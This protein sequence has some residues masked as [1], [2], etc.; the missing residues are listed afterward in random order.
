MANRGGKRWI[1]LLLDILSVIAALSL[2]LS[3]FS[4]YTHPDTF[5]IIPVFGLAYPV[6]V[7]VF[8]LVM[9]VQVFFKR[10]FAL[11][12]FVLFLSG[13]GL[14]LRT[15][16]FGSGDEP[17]KNSKSLKIMSYNVRLFDFYNDDPK[18][19]Q[20]SRHKILEFLKDE[21]PDIVCFQEFYQQDKPTN[22][23]TKDTIIP[24][25][26]IKDY[27]ERYT[28][29]ER[30]R[31]N[32]GIALFS[33]YP[34]IEKGE[35]RFDSD[36]NS[37][38]YSIYSDIV[39]HK[40]T[41]RVY[42]IHL[43]SISLDSEE[44]AALINEKSKTGFFSAMGKVIEA[45]PERAKQ[46]E[47]IMNHIRNSPYPVVVCGDFNDTPLSYT[48]QRF[49]NHLTDAY[50]N[51]RTGIG[52]TYAGEI[53]AGRIDYIFHSEALGSHQF[54]IQENAL[55]DHYAISCKVFVK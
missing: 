47:R 31:R 2:L 42:N 17:P 28:H 15:F 3:Y 16:T 5:S 49:H 22:F 34:I 50:R 30:G 9:I 18:Q 53:P 44:R 25:L 32:Y 46:A 11:G 48:Y 54:K 1:R 19:A 55:S 37:F 39:F 33:K 51:C 7:I 52:K 27:Q 6:I 10:W 12:M 45:F 21:S 36:L 41:I 26:G 29:V 8:I 14:H 23:I 13:L 35:V 38:N 24:L 40:D 4:P 20:L 43:Q